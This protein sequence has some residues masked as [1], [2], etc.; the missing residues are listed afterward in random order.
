[1]PGLSVSDVIK[2]DINMSPKAVP[3]RN[4]GALCLAGPSPVIDVKERIREYAT[5]DEVA[6]DF[7]S[8]APE[9]GAA[10]LFFSQSPQPSILYIGRFA[11]GSTSA[12]LHGAILSGVQQAALM[13]SLRAVVNGT[14]AITI[15]GT[16]RTVQAAAAVLHGGAFTT[17]EQG[18]LLA[19]LQALT[20]GAFSITID[21]VAV[22]T[23][24]IDFTGIL[25]LADA[26]PLIDAAL[27]AATV[28]FD[29]TLGDFIVRSTTTGVASTITYAAAPATG[30]DIS[31]SLRLTAASGALAPRPG[32]TGMDFS[33]ITNLN[34]AASILSNALIG[35]TC[36]WDGTRF[37]I[38]SL[39]RGI[40]SS[41]SYA[42]PAGVG[43]DI[44]A[45]LRL[46]QA[47][48]A[49][50]PVDGMTAET[51][52][53]CAVA[54]RAHPQWYGFQFALATDIPVDAYVAVAD[55]IEGS[56]PRSIFGYTTP[57]TATLDPTVTDDIMSQMKALG[58]SRTFGQYSSSSAW[59]SA[60]AFARA[61]TV[62]FEASDTV[63]TLKFKQEPGVAGELLTESQA[64]TLKHKNGNVFVYYDNDTAILQEGEMANGFFFDEIH[65][66]DWLANRIQTDMFNALYTAPTKLPQTNPGVHVLVTTMTSS[67]EQGV[68]NGMIA[69]GQW[70]AP[71][72]G[73]LKQGQMLP[74]GYYVW[75][76]LVETQ[77]QSIRE[78]RIAPTIQAAIKMAGAIHYAGAIV[79]VNR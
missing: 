66:T 47:T 30:T 3:L 58:F 19:E 42:R 36:T 49:S 18:V 56:N 34:G 6:A 35:A 25:A 24:P 12:V 50:M 28:S 23:G 71:G 32:N 13:T 73:Q 14:M 38:E 39:S 64:A 10:D 8:A 67:I 26:G 33:A 4:F 5:L 31:A 7:G 61:F 65:T 52:L 53:A 51:P 9:Y 55:F 16:A 62:D 22:D 21:G 37:H 70:N 72:F 74:T 60:S 11:Q 20:D 68:T 27:A 79:T 59:A 41:L 77:P 63:I 46:T 44:S 75:A 40:A 1:M 2:V 29:A 48:G 54:L 76:P 57:D 78:Q 45:Q 69:P 17:P 43:Q 15:D